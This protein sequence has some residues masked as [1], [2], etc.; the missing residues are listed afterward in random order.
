VSSGKSCSCFTLIML[1]SDRRRQYLQM[2]SSVSC[3][4]T[5]SWLRLSLLLVLLRSISQDTWPSGRRSALCSG[6]TQQCE[7]TQLQR[8][9]ACLKA[10]RSRLYRLEVE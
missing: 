2:A 4:K 10:L 7:V 9:L 6:L 3:R 5:P 8:R 1:T